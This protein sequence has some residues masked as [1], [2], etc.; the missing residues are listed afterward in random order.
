MFAPGEK[1]PNLRH[2]Q[3]ITNIYQGLISNQYQ[4][5]IVYILCECDISS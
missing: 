5:N 3:Y 1:N 2:S 4:V